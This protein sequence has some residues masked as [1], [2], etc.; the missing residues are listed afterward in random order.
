MYGIT[1]L[2]YSER[3]PANVRDVNTTNTVEATLFIHG[4][5]MRIVQMSAFLAFYS[6]KVEVE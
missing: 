3:I 4:T 5:L 1:V 6:E 2:K